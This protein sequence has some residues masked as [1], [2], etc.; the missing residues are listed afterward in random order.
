MV[1]R[2][3]GLVML[4][5]VTFLLFASF[6]FIPRIPQPLS[7]HDF[8]DRRSWL[9]VPNFGNVVSNLPFAFF[10]IAGLVFLFTRASG[11]AFL[12][13]GERQPY[14]FVFL[15]LFLTAFGSGY[16]HWNPSNATLLWDRLPMTIA[17]M[18]IVAA[19]I[20]ERISVRAGLISLAPLLIL[21][22]ASPIQWYLSELHGYGDLRFYAAVQL[23]AVLSLPLFLL[24]FPPRY[25]R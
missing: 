17:F 23:A 19:L 6:F 24:L 15:G 7:Y 18:G 10:G 12:D 8:A 4:F 5:A 3:T 16:Y 22:A 9:G 2:R 21:G 13:R 1:S 20:A 14:F 11:A 25:T